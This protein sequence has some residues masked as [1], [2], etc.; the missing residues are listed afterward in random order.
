MPSPSGRASAPRLV[1]ACA[2]AALLAQHAAAADPATRAFDPDP[3]R[4]AALSG[5]AFAVETAAREARGSAHLE[6][7]LDYARGLLAL[8]DGD[9]K[10]GDLLRDRLAFHLLGSYAL[11]PFELGADLPFAAYQGSNLSLLTARGVT[12]PLVDPIASTA[13]GDVRLVGKAPLPWRAGPLD[14]AVLAD[15]RLPTGDER[16]FTS[17][18][19]AVNPQLLAGARLGPVRLDA[20]AGWLFRKSGQYLQLVARDAFTYGVGAQLPL[21]R[22]G[23]LL[24]W[25]AIADV[26]GQVPRG[27]DSSTAR[28]RA[29]LSVRG[30]VRARLW[31]DLGVEAGLGTGVA[32]FGDA[33]YGRESFRAFLGLR[34]E[35]AGVEGEPGA[36]TGDRD[37]DGVPDDRDRC[38]DEPGPAE[39]DGCPDR[40]GDGIA[41]LDDKCPDAP[42]PPQSDGC[43][44]PANQPD[45]EIETSRLSLKEAI[46]FD[47]GRDTIRPESSRIIQSIATILQAHPELKRLRI[48][49][50]TDNRG[51]RPYNL[52]LSQRRA[53]AVVRALV[54]RG[55]AEG[56]LEAAGY[57][58]DRPIATNATSLGRAKNRRVDITILTE[59]P[60]S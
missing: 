5:G 47:T 24:D 11:G 39:L 60:R 21:P 53:R 37:G 2:T 3:S 13:L 49:G 29:P 12:G 33:G 43:P 15:L 45:V 48:E 6:L 44:P 9:A 26:A 8:K 32:W 35:R 10:V 17:D 54:A 14:L 34:W 40:D 36:G 56:R 57:G 28:Y 50:H 22:V 18:G 42:G 23:R 7:L 52:D 19:L 20:S 46:T 51:A 1:V 25:R 38:P 31:R 41:D 59:G 58:F 27:I 55:V 16:A 4:P 30:G